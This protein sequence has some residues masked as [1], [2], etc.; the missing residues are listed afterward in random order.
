MAQDGQDT[1]RAWIEVTPGEEGCAILLR[2]WQATPLPPE[3]ADLASRHRAE[4]DRALAELTARLD[5][6]QG[7]LSAEA[8]GPELADLAHAMRAGAG[9][10]WTDF[11]TLV[12]MEHRQPLHWRLLDGAAV[13]VAGSARP[14]R[15]TLIAQ[16]DADGQVL[17]FDLCLTSEVPAAQPA[18]LAAPPRPRRPRARR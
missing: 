13:K 16:T 6:A 1:I 9:R 18:P 7:V 5:A 8:Y 14:W 10:A 15:S 12:G 4:I 2:N 3:P 11:V 17:G